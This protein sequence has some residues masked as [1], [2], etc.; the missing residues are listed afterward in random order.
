MDGNG[1]RA[2]IMSKNSGQ[3]GTRRICDEVVNAGVRNFGVMDIEGCWNNV[4][5][6]SLYGSYARMADG[7]R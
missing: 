6:L 1:G 3:K 4:R 5:V 7:A 2:C